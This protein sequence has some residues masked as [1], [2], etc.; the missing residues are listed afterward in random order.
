[1]FSIRY[2][3]T[4]PSQ[5]KKVMQLERRYNKQSLIGTCHFNDYTKVGPTSYDV[6]ILSTHCLSTQQ[7]PATCHS[8]GR[9]II[10]NIII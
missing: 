4:P 5:T 6:E 7:A 3:H 9:M 8:A 1:M 10:M 2:L